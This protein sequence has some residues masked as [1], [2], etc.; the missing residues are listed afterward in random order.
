MIVKDNTGKWIFV[1]VVTLASLV[2]SLTVT[3]LVA[4]PPTRA[5]GLKIATLVP[6][7]VAPIASLV[8]AQMMLRIYRLNQRLHYMA[9][10][11]Q[12]TG[13][14]NRKAFFDGIAQGAHTPK[15]SV[16][17]ADIDKFKSINDT[18]GHQVGDVVICKVAE[19]LR[20]KSR[21]NG[22]AARLGG[23][24]F[25][26]FYPDT[27]VTEATQ[28]AEDIRTTIASQTLDVD[29]TTVHCTLSIGIAFCDGARP[30]DE[31]VKAADQALYSAKRA[32]RN[33]VI[34]HCDRQIH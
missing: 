32:G 31:Y 12:M 7:I 14:L 2:A 27:C 11:D 24:E 13:L 33:Q 9:H 23:E 6:L 15:G 18:Y 22:I 4:T 26:A 28:K 5:T 10:H 21:Q 3:W 34:R 30:I 1:L 17:I 19:I 8:A 29:G 16:I 25:V 20:D